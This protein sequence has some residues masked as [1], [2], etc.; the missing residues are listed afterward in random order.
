MKMGHSLFAKLIIIP[1][2]V[3]GLSG[4]SLL[5][6][7]FE[8]FRASDRYGDE[9]IRRHALSAAAGQVGTHIKLGEW[10]KIDPVLQTVRGSA[11]SDEASL[12]FA[13]RI[14]REIRRPRPDPRVLRSLG[15][16]WQVYQLNEVMRLVDDHEAAFRSVIVEGWAFWLGFAVLFVLIARQM[17]HYAARP[18]R[19]LTEYFR[20][21]DLSQGV[22]PLFPDTQARERSG[23]D[24]AAMEIQ[25]LFRG[26]ETLVDRVQEFRNINIHRLM[27]QRA[28]AEVLASASRDAIFFLQGSVVVWCNQISAGLLQIASRRSALPINLEKVTDPRNGPLA[29]AVLVARRKDTPVE[30]SRSD[31]DSDGENASFLFSKASGD[32]RRWGD[33]LN[34]DAVIIGQN[35]SWIRQ[36]ENAKS[37][38]VG[39]LSHEVKTPVTSLL[40]ATRLLQRA[41]SSLAPVQKKLVDSSVRD[42]ER[43]RVLIDELFAASRFDLDAERLNFRLVDLRRLVSQAVRSTRTEAEARCVSMDLSFECPDS[44]VMVR[45]D[46]PRVSWALT[47][48]VTFV[49]RHAPRN[50]RVEVRMSEASLESGNGFQIVV[51]SV[52][53][54]PVEDPGQRIFQR[55]FAHYDLR[56]ARSNSNGMALAI[57]RE[58]AVGHGGTLA[59]NPEYRDGAEFILT[60]P[61]E[62]GVDA[63]IRAEC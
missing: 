56:V 25:A 22:Q 3:I 15:E 20:T 50:S 26:V 47:Q 44:E 63:V 16:A 1:A 38:F 46:A 33:Q 4:L 29:R 45:I 37:H 19:Y 35:V 51:R 27:E 28:R 54:P 9:H 21:M 12:A 13:S 57:A 7:G 23:V 24:N 39:L 34:F 43:L 10:D 11:T 31:S 60:L 5:M 62:R 30:W 36:A 6:V 41:A 61:R 18:V 8:G 42:V 2:V 53:A 17:F 58:I 32:W 48:L 49:L 52:G 59:L 40:M 14:A 55:T